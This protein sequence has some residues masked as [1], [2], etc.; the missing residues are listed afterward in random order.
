VIRPHAKDAVPLVAAARHADV[1][2]RSVQRWLA[3][4]ARA[5]WSRSPAGGR[6]DRRRHRLPSELAML[7]ESLALGSPRPTLAATHRQ[8]SEVA[9]Q[10]GAV[11]SYGSVHAIVTALDPGASNRRNLVVS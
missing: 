7:I 1:P 11:P 9:A 10:R 6:S 5:G 8:A 3:C 4:T 2:L